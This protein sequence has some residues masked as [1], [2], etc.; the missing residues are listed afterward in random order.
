MQ[1][2]LSGAE[3]DTVGAWLLSRAAR[4]LRRSGHDVS[5]DGADPTAL[6]LLQLVESNSAAC[7]QPVNVHVPG[8]FEEI[9]RES[10]AATAQL[11]RLLRVHR[12][13]R[14]HRGRV[15]GQSAQD[16]LEADCG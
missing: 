3:L 13:N 11:R 9:G 6:R 10:E 1:F 14:E 5:I 15:G 8:M 2:D 7:D 12:R 16:A 4:D